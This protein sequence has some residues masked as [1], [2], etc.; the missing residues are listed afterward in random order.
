[1]IWILI[2]FLKHRLFI[3]RTRLIVLSI[4]TWSTWIILPTINTLFGYGF[5][6]N[7]SSHVFLM[8]KMVDNGMLVKYLNEDESAKRFKL[9]AYR[10]SLPITSSDFLWSPNSVLYKT[11]G[12]EIN[13]EEYNQILNNIIL[14]K[15]YLP[16]YIGKS[17]IETIEQLTKNDFGEEYY[18][19]YKKEDPPSYQIEWRFK[20]DYYSY[21]KAQ[22]FGGYQK[23]DFAKGSSFQTIL[24][25]LSL[26][27][28]VTHLIHTRARGLIST[29]CIITLLFIISNAI[30]TATLSSVVPRYNSRV[31]WYL[32][33][34]AVIIVYEYVLFMIKKFTPDYFIKT[35]Q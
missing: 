18:V 7:N 29:I 25:A 27:I 32:L 35:Y 24:I 14:S 31:T 6:T 8:G 22:Q 2:T 16:E 23:L 34:I 10:D 11:G 1:M 33:F 9:Y 20:G 21:T 15:N 12:W 13:K 5:R 17:I 28:I 4:L 30:V 3:N 19:S 26:L